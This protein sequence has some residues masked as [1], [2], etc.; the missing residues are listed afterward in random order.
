MNNYPELEIG[1]YIQQP[2][3]YKAFIPNNFPPFSFLDINPSIS[4]KHT[5]AI[6]L[7]GE[8]NGI[9]RLLPDVN[10]F[11]R[12]FIMK[13][14]SN[15]SQ[16]EGT[17]ATMEDAIEAENIDRKPNLPDDVDDILHYIKALDYG[18]EKLRNDSPLTLNFIRELHGRLIAGARSTQHAYPGE[19]RR[20]QNW[21]GGTRP[22][23]AHFVPPPVHDMKCSLSDLE[24]FIHSD[25]DYLP[26]VKA[27][28]IHAQFETIHPFTDGNG[29]TGRMLITFYLWFADLLRQ[30]VLY[31]SSYFKK[32][33][34]IYYDKLSGYHD[35]HV[36]EWIEYF[37]DAII[38]VANSA[39]ETCDGI[40]QLYD[41]DTSKIQ[42]LGQRE[43][44]STMH[45][46]KMLYKMPT[47]GIADVL[48]AS[49][50]TSR[51]GAYKVVN[52]L[53][54]MGILYPTSTTSKNRYGQKWIYKDYIQLFNNYDEKIEN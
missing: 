23:N 46:L 16:I 25:E 32:Y 45:T 7:L 14:A 28:L 54:D 5:E 24:N 39:I 40:V 30:P 8:L 43:S 11:L 41:R 53:V 21:I 12:M 1:K 44:E 20:S 50:L 31:L 49:G 15:S 52:R 38:D 3:G 17:K 18:L 22:D 4:R 48:Q 33:Q 9:T 35:G 2:A 6:K 13:D 51:A 27:A 36:H 26:L 19:F 10:C 37:L 29:R 47:V 34:Q 42:L